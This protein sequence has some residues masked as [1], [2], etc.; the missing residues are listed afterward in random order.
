MNKDQDA[1]LE[2]K[3]EFADLP[4]KE[5]PDMV[6]SDNISLFDLHE[7]MQTVDAIPVE[8]LNKRVKAEDDELITEVFRKESPD[9]KR[10]N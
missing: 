1:F 9:E 10:H 4:A 2:S 5:K 8:E 3:K 7:D 6:D